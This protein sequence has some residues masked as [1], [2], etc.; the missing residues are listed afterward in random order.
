[1]QIDDLLWIQEFED[2]LW[3]KHRVTAEEAEFVLFTTGHV[4]FVE[5]GARPAEDL[6]AA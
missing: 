3:Q 6:Y 1:M 2:K 5:K 4:R